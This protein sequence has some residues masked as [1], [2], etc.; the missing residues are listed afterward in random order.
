M[1]PSISIFHQRDEKT[2]LH[3]KECHS[4]MARI[5]KENQG[6]RKETT[7]TRYER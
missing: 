5:L 7:S 3:R 4:P 6:S 1:L 2:L